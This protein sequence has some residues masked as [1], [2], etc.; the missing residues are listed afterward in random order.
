MFESTPLSII[1]AMDQNRLIGK[2]NK[3]PWR[4]P[5]DLAYFRK[6]TLGHNVIMG[7]N[8][9]LSLGKAL[10]QRTN[11]VLSGDPHFDIPGLILVRSLSELEEHLGSQESFIIGGASLFS[12]FLPVATKLHITRIEARF[13][14]DTWFPDYAE[15]EWK[16]VFYERIETSEGLTLSFNEY[17]RKPQE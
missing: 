13:E 5:E 16:Q 8:T 17:I 15:A 14:G 12:Q 10:D 7:K 9:W 1:V 4:I 6:T 3:L 2:D 11:I